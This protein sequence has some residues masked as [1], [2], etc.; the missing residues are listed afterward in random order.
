[1]EYPAGMSSVGCRSECRIYPAPKGAGILLVLYNPVPDPA[2][3][4]VALFRGEF[5]LEEHDVHAAD[6][7]EISESVH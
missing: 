1:M 5:R 3:D 7:V 4:S 6:G 2:D